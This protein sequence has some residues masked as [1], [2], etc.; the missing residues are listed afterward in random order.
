MGTLTRV[1]LQGLQIQLKEVSFYYHDKTASMGP[2]EFTGLLEFTLPPQGV[3]VDIVVR[4]IP[5]SPEGKREREKRESFLDIQRV[6]V[7][8]SEDVNLG[9]GGMPNGL[10]DDAVD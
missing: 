2:S 6:G 10:L 8:V 9:L 7:K 1:Y 5:N 4:S 3:D